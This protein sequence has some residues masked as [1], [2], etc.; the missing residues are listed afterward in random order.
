M[1]NEVAANDAS[2]L[3]YEI[4]LDI[5]RYGLIYSVFAY[6][7]EMLNMDL[8]SLQWPELCWL[9]ADFQRNYEKKAR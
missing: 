1:H 6:V 9:F 8:S 2:I 5:I 7:S 4:L 3:G